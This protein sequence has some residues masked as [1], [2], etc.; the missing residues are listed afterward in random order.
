MHIVT[1]SALILL[2]IS[3]CFAAPTKPLNGCG[4]AVRKFE[5]VSTPYIKYWYSL[6]ACNLGDPTKLNV[7]LVPHSHDDVGWL[8]TVDEYYYGGVLF[9]V[10]LIASRLS[11]LSK[12]DLED[13]ILLKNLMQQKNI[14]IFCSI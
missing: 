14:S 6:Q 13:V 7:H 10:I 2:V 5:D 8:K 9:Q 1:Y 4:Y 12:K 11:Y 3:L